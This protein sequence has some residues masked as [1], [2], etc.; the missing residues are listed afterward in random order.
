MTSKKREEYSQTTKSLKICSE[1]L[2]K[3]RN[4][5][6]GKK[7]RDGL[8]IDKKWKGEEGRTNGWIGM[9]RKNLLTH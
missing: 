6:A 7:K 2:E 8:R 5:N 9:I 3:L 1:C 4:K